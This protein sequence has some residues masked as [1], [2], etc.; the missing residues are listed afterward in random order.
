M[1]EDV[2]YDAFL[3]RAKELS[4]TIRDNMQA[5]SFF[6]VISHHD[7]D[8]LS[9][10]SIVGS[11][12]SRAKARFTIR[13]VE[14]L[15]EDIL[16]E[17]SKT[18]PEVVIFS[19]IGSGYFD[20]LS[21]H[22]NA[23]TSLVLD[24]HPPD[25]EAPKNI[26]QLNP[27]EFGVDGA[28]LVSAA[29]VCYFV[30]RELSGQNKDL[31]AMAV[32]GA[33]GDMQDKNENRSLVGLNRLIVEDSVAS[34][35]I[36]VDSDL[37]LYGR[38]T[39]PIHRALAYTTTPYLPN[40]SGR[41]DNCLTLL[42]TNGIKVKEGD[43]FR[44]VADL[45]Q[46]EKQKLLNAIISYLA[47]I[48]FQS[49]VVLDMVGSVYTLINEP[50]GSPTRDGREFS[51]LLNACGRTG[52]PSIGISVGL[53]DRKTALEEANE[54]VTTYRKT[55]ASYMDWL[56]KSPDAVQKFQS[57]WVVRGENQIQDSMTGAFSSILSS[58]G[59]LSPDHATIVLTRSKEGGIKLSARA[60]AKL[61]DRGVNLGLALSSVSK[62]YNGF[63]GG[64]NVAAGAHIK[65]ED[66]SEFLK[67]LDEA[68]LAQM[69]PDIG[70]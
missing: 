20:L 65:V 7:A 41:E 40:L 60:P 33:L 36:R 12:L 26:A 67:E 35:S 66:P 16:E 43:R 3:A 23:K 5:D 21:N 18:N 10:A 58:A 61:L 52:N 68:I 57:I 32:V 9:S 50:A 31:S 29:G 19:D 70:R 56:T 47:S 11:A 54:V 45:T 64:H 44:T 30:A 39:R 27:H 25:A 15:R 48:G 63:G 22:L 42:S 8:G 17:I 2:S 51:A 53:G 1:A 14:E 38:E 37:V 69:K 59:S 13:I 6:T 55:L 28:K 62:K 46:D 4:G 34:G 24:H 49:S